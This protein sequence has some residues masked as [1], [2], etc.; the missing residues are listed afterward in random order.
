MGYSTHGKSGTRLY[1]I[2]QG[3]KQRCHDKHHPKYK[4]YGARGIIVCQEWL[5][6]F[7]NFYDWAINNGYQENLTINRINTNGNYEPDNCNW[8]TNLEQQHN[9]TNSVTLEYNGKSLCI[10]EWARLLN[11]PEGT[12][13][14]RHKRG[15][16]D[17]ECLAGRTYKNVG[18]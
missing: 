10:S 2:W 3:M 8:L 12:I 15:W 16:P 5:D 4:N 11:V 6:D 14:A 13:R 17:N 7:M 1:C 9:K 18:L